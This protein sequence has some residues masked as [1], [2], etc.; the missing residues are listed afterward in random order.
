MNLHEKWIGCSVIVTPNEHDEFKEFIGTCIGIRNGHLQV[1]DQ[2]DDT[3]EVDESQVTFSDT[4][5]V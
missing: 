4:D 2:D 1:N 3:W 5:D